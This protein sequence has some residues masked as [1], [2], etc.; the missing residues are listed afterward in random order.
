MT[1]LLLRFYVFMARDWSINEYDQYTND[2]ATFLR[3]RHTFFVRRHLFFGGV[4]YFWA[5]SFKDEAES[6]QLW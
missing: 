2:S 5:E 1:L 6:V 4:I 3:L